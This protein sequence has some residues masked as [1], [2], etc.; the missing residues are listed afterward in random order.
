VTDFDPNKI[1]LTVVSNPKGRGVRCVYL[2]NHRIVGSKP[3]VT[4]DLPHH[5]FSTSQDELQRAFRCELAITLAAQRMETAPKNGTL[6]ILWLAADDAREN[7]LEDSAELTPTIGFNNFEHDAVDEWKFAGWC[8]DH[9]HFTAGRGTPVAW[10][11]FPD[12][13]HDRHAAALI[14][15]YIA[16]ADQT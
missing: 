8:W 15:A 16:K 9:D 11:P 13:P 6:V 12:S 2:G 5:N 7:P 10:Q 3:Y 1:P 14:A 4:E